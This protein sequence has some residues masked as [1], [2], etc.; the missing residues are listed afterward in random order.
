MIRRVL[1]GAM[2]GSPEV[3]WAN[4]SRVTE[5]AAVPA[6]SVRWVSNRSSRRTSP[7]SAASASSSPLKVLVSEPISKRLSGPTSPNP[8]HA[9]CPSRIRTT[10]MALKSVPGARAA[11]ASRARTASPVG[12]PSAAGRGPSTSSIKAPTSAPISSSNHGPIRW[13]MTCS[14]GLGL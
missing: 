10:L 13:S 2:L 11:V 6:S 4:S 7:R 8:A 1:I 5:P 3:C 9:G 14:M 12:V